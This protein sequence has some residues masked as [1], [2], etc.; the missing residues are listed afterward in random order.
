VCLNVSTE[1]E[2]GEVVAVG[3]AE[4]ADGVQVAVAWVGRV[5]LISMV[6]MFLW[7]GAICLMSGR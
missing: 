1:I 5:V 7:W 3:V 6:R 4:E 2:G